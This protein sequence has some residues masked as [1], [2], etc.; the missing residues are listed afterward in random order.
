MI[1]D[2][3]RP[4]T[5]VSALGCGLMGGFL[6]A[7]SVCVMR[8]L[9]RLPPSA[10]ISAMQSINIVVIN[11]LFLTAFLGTAAVSVILTIFSLLRLRQPGAIFVLIGSFLYLAGTVLVTFVFNVPRNNVLVAVE[12]ASADAAALWTDYVKI[13]TAWN[14]VRTFAALTAALSFTIALYYSG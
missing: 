3:I 10:G 2:L 13:W 1:D 9:A 14:H 7:F 12:P 11:P 8:A 5:L 4:F 6:F